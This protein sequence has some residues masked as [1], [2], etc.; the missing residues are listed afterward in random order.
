[1]LKRLTITKAEGYTTVT[2]DKYADRIQ[3]KRT[4]IPS[5]ASLLRLDSLLQN[6]AYYNKYALE[7]WTSITIWQ[8]HIELGYMYSIPNVIPVNTGIKEDLLELGFDP[9]TVDEST[10]HKINDKVEDSTMPY[11][12]NLEALA[13]SYGIPRKEST[14]DDN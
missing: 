9:S 12:D 11:W 5:H 7:S 8:T 4:Y 14:L 2:I 3:G 1:M 10:L 6:S 13:W